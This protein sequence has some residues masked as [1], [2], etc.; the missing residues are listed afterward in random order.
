MQE[1]KNIKLLLQEYGVEETSSSFNNDIMQRVNAALVTKQSKPLLN[2]FIIRLLKL[3]FL[4][5]AISVISIVCFVP[6][7]N[8]YFNIHNNI[9]NQLFTFIIVF[10]VGMLMNICLN[11]IWSKKTVLYN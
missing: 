10:W 9:F 3:A 8:F 5:V 7:L 6:N 11:K 4:I 2:N 1:D